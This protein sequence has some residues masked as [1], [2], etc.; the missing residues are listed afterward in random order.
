[1]YRSQLHAY[2]RKPNYWKRVRLTLSPSIAFRAVQ[3][4][5]LEKLYGRIRNSQAQLNNQDFFIGAYYRSKMLHI[6]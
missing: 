1:L 2:H 6:I 4:T 5:S 3:L